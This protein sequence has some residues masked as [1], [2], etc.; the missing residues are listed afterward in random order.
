MHKIAISTTF[1][2]KLLYAIYQ[3]SADNLNLVLQ[4]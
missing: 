4:M 2:H 3:S 1:D